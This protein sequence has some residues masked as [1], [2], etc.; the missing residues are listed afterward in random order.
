MFDW[1]KSFSVH[2]KDGHDEMINTMSMMKGIFGL[3]RLIVVAISSGNSLGS[4]NSVV[5][6]SSSQSTNLSIQ[7]TPG[8]GPMSSQRATKIPIIEVGDFTIAQ[9]E[10]LM[11]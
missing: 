2:L 5:K 10:D 8:S 6:A 3:L 4:I 7:T 9:I 11:S 1:Q